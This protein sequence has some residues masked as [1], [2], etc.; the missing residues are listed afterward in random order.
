MA[1]VTRRGGSWGTREVAVMVEVV[2][3]VAHRLAHA[4]AVARAARVHHPLRAAAQ[5]DLHD[6]L[7]RGEIGRD[8]AR[9][10]EVRG[11]F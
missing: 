8:E 10:A 6:D 5:L 2:A 3:A 7:A 4:A 11:G 9:P 1:A